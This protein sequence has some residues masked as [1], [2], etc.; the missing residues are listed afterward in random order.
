LPS[1]VLT[2]QAPAKVNLFLAVGPRRPD[3]YHSVLTLLETI[4]L[5]DEVRVTLSPA[6]GGRPEITAGGGGPGLAP[7][8]RF[9]RDLDNLAGRAAVLY[10]SA[11][12]GH[13]GRAPSALAVDVKVTKRIPMAAGLGGGSSDAAAVLRALERWSGHPL[14]SGRLLS[15]A[16]R[17][18]SDVPF[19]VRGGRA[20]GRGRGER[21][22]FLE[23]GPGLHLVL[24]LTTFG[25][26]TAGVYREFDRSSELDRPHP[27]TGRPN[28]GPG[29][30]S[31]DG[32][33]G[34]LR[35]MAG[36]CPE[37]A[38]LYLRNDLA[39]A[40]E[41][42]RPEIGAIRELLLR[43]GCRAALVSGSG[44]T[45]FGLAL[46]EEQAQ[47]AAADAG[48]RLPPGLAGRVKF[49]SVRTLPGLRLDAQAQD[50]PAG[51]TPATGNVNSV[52][53]HS[54]ERE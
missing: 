42:L 36:G 22:S 27:E 51:G 48:R 52:D 44:P 43:G 17:L 46:D 18:G 14:G 30:E 3:G 1:A 39:G 8:D 11:L 26:S 25:L 7:G 10:L 6:P 13:E 38:A 40:A 16:A 2:E 4:S 53:V 23:P 5:A 54:P 45:V 9:P 15:L 19:L 49:V 37:E 20:V 31:E 28:A 32:L 50:P 21:V 47:R 35:A 33:A 34:L 12:A 41:R 29:P 24:A